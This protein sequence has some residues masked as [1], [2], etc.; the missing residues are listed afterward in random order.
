MNKR[1]S[2]FNVAEKI[3]ELKNK[4]NMN[5]SDIAKILNVSNQA[6]SKQI[7]RLYNGEN[8]GLYSII[9]IFEALEDDFFYHRF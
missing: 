7:R 1:N 9:A 2:F 6:V 3:E 4:K 5:N 8:C